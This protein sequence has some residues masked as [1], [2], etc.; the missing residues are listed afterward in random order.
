MRLGALG[1]EDAGDSCEVVCD[2]DV[3]P[4][5]SFEERANGGKRVV[6]EF[7]DEQAAGFEVAGGLEDELGVE[8]VAFFTAV[9]GG[10]GFVI[11]DLDRERVGFFATDVGGVGDYQIEGK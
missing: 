2:V 7:E 5:R 4:F 6:A 3:D 10:G 11:A 8:F 1:R 9:E